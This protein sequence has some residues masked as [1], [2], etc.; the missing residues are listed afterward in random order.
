MMRGKYSITMWAVIAAF[1]LH[2]IAQA[3]TIVVRATGPSAASYPQG[4]ALPATQRVVLRS[5][6][7]VTLLGPSGTR[8]LAGPGNYPVTPPP[9]SEN[10]RRQIALR[11]AAAMTR[12][13]QQSAVG[14]TRR[15]LPPPADIAAELATLPA[16]PALWS[17][18][19]GLR[20]NF[21]IPDLS[22]M[23]FARAD[24]GSAQSVTVLRLRRP[25]DRLT[26]TFG[27]TATVM[28]WTGFALVDGDQLLIQSSGQF[29]IRVRLVHIPGVPDNA[30][31]L[32]TLL[33]ARGCRDQLDQLSAIMPADTSGT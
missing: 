5:G 29:P 21:C 26:Q 27:D 24:P 7:R 19:I 18:R 16:G 25:A 8:T 22:E 9:L 12:A 33:A 2:G 15:V 23:V 31:D 11:Y 28:R 13:Q 3:N 6:D 1:A 14:G 30:A 17:Y 4:R 20:G 10:A 32:A